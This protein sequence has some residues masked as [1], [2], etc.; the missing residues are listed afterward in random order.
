MGRTASIWGEDC[1]EF[2]PE[3]WITDD[4]GIKHEPPH[5]FFVFSA[6]SRICLGKEIAFTL[7]KAIIA[8]IVHT[9]DV[10]VIESHPVVPSLSVLFLMKHG[11]MA[12][13]NKRRAKLSE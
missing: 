13:I 6:G 9:Y 5:K 1:H 3:R 8:T 4:G 2:K 10:Q 11:L 7:M 12:R